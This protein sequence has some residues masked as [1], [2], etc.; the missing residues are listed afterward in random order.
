MGEE[1][2]KEKNETK[3]KKDE[4]PKDHYEV[5]GLPRN[6]TL[7][8]IKGAY[9]KLAL[10]YHPDKNPDPEAVPIFLD[11]QQA[12]QVL[13]DPELRRRYDAG[14]SV[15]DEAGGKAMK[16]MRY[17]IIEVDRE[18]GIAKVWWYDPNTGEEGTMEMEVDKEEE[19]P[20]NESVRRTLRE[21]CCLPR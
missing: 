7:Q 8:E 10:K 6:A 16:P 20:S 5:L 11:V 4:K 9:R 13:S 3:K 12:Y 19:K 15:D 17:K 2:E 18:R 21:H 14:Q 1:Q